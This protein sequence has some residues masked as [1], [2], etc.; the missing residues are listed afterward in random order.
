MTNR[1]HRSRSDAMLGGVCAGIAEYLGID[2]TI[3]RLFFVIFTLVNG[4]AVL[5]YLVLWLVLPAEGAETDGTLEMNV[6][7]GADEIA[8]RARAIGND[9]RGFAERRDPRT[10]LF[11]GVALLALGAFY[12][13]RNLGVSWMSWFNSDLIWPALLIL[14][15]AWLLVARRR[16]G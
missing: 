16:D 14:A 2:P 13:L 10:G 6:R 15:G 11:V 5:A 4:A 8:S 7:S 9:V 12:L 3:V 1:L